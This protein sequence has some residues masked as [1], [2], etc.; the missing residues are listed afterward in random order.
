MKTIFYVGGF[1]LPDKNAAAQR[2]INN[3]KIF[4][5][6][7]YN[8]VFIGI[9]KSLPKNAN[10]LETKENYYGFDCWSV[11]YPKTKASWLKQLGTISSVSAVMGEYDKDSLF[12]LICYNHYALAQAR[13]QII[14]T[15]KKMLCIAD[16]TEWYKAEGTNI[17]VKAFKWLDVSAR[18]K[19]VH[20][21]A[22]GV[23]TTSK[24]LNSYYTSH[25]CK[26]VQLPTLF[27]SQQLNVSSLISDKKDN[28]YKQI[29]YA[30]NP[31]NVVTNDK[32]SI[33]D[34]LDYVV[35]GM[36]FV[37]QAGIKA[38]LNI[39][40]VD[41][42]SYLKVFPE[43]GYILKEMTDIVIFHGRKPHTEII[44]RI[45]LA[46]FTIFIREIDRVTEAGFPTKFSES[47]MCGTPVLT[48]KISNIEKYL[49]E[50]VSGFSLDLKNSNLRNRQ[51]LNAL[52]CTS[53]EIK[54]MKSY[55]SE[56]MDFDFRSFTSPVA[57]FLDQLT[58]EV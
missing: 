6:L 53:E 32:S 46:D 50:G 26:T 4:K 14:C 5:E 58:G 39:F 13:L 27:D 41:K 23:I 42:S 16:A 34:R 33:K 35:E 10:V 51:L 57:Y 30:G 31:F 43:H 25:G 45:K 55:C 3:G 48:N 29:I 19:F 44:S 12:A 20:C 54:K 36:S 15:R 8:V 1:E 40:G 24:Y 9:D 2:V 22:D 38:Q 17:F 47:I 56:S 11:P 18:M 52:S 37:F 7:G 21:K 49:D 28:D